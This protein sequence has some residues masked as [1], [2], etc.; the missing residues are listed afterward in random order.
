[1]YVVYPSTVRKLLTINRQSD[2]TASTRYSSQIEDLTDYMLAI[3]AENE[4]E[5]PVPTQ[6]ASASGNLRISILSGYDSLPSAPEPDDASYYRRQDDDWEKIDIWD[7]EPYTDT[8]GAAP[9]ESAS[10]LC[11]P[12]K[13]KREVD[14]ASSSTRPSKVPKSASNSSSTSSPFAHI[15]EK[16]PV[17]IVGVQPRFNTLISLGYISQAHSD[18]YCDLLHQGRW[19]VQWELARYVS[20]ISDLNYSDLT[21][22]ELKMLSDPRRSHEAGVAELARILK[23]RKGMMTSAAEDDQFISAFERERTARVSKDTSSSSYL[24]YYLLQDPWDELDKEHM[25]F[26][27]VAP[28]DLTYLH[29][30]EDG[31][32][33]GKVHFTA[34]LKFSES[35]NHRIEL[36]RPFLGTSCRFSRRFGSHSFVRIRIDKD[37]IFRSDHHLV[38]Y[39]QRPFIIGGWVFRAFYS[40][41]YNVFLF[42]TNEVVHTIPSG[43]AS[44]GQPGL[45][46][47]GPHKTGSGSTVGLSLL[48]FLQWHNDISLNSA[49]VCNRLIDLYH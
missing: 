11:G 28:G 21:F 6:P 31:D 35:G 7:L 2:G 9:A 3:P 20:A 48:E 10:T 8:S 44:P 4:G 18:L 24:V 42:K 27:N 13:R 47:R 33:G 15:T 43:S 5:L 40:K 22:H 19:G 34:R 32:Y 46:I 23:E 38:K 36:N 49:Q 37:T 45:C 39:F 1:M 26:S 30:A 25:Y 14:V 16:Q 41:E 29:D 12:A 17:V